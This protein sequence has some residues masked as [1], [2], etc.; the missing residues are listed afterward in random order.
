MVSQIILQQMSEKILQDSGYKLIHLFK[1]NWSNKEYCLRELDQIKHVDTGQEVLFLMHVLKAE[2]E[3]WWHISVLHA[4][5][6]LCSL[7]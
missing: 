7:H 1:D 3:M 4:P 5:N 6:F 2:S